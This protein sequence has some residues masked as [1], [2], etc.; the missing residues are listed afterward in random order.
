MKKVLSFMFAAAFAFAAC[1]PEEKVVPVVDVTMSSFGFYAVTNDALKSDFVVENPS[2]NIRIVLPY[3]TEDETLKSLVPTFVVTDGAVVTV[4]GEAVESGVTAF[5]FRHT[6][7]FL[8][9]VNEKSN[10]QYTV[11]VSVSG[12]AKWSK[13][14]VSEET[15]KA[16]IAL[17][18]GPVDESLYMFGYLKSTE[19]DS[20][21]LM[22]KYSDETI[23]AVSDVLDEVAAKYIA[24]NCSADG[25]P[26]S[27]FYDNTN[28]KM[29]VFC[30]SEGR[31]EEVGDASSLLANT[32]NSVGSNAIVPISRNDVWAFL[33]NNKADTNLGLIK[34]GLNVCHYDGNSWT[35]NISLPDWQ[36]SSA[37]Y[38]MQTKW[39]KG[40]PYIFIL[41][42]TLARLFVYK[43]EN[44][45][46]VTVCNG[47]QPL[48]NDGTTPISTAVY[49]YAAMNFD[50][51]SN[52]DIYLL[53]AADY[54]V[55]STDKVIGV[56]KYD[57][58]TKACTLV[59]GLYKNT[60]ISK[61]RY[62]SMA[63]DAN[64]VPY[65]V[66]GNTFLEGTPAYV[67]YV[68][69]KSKVWSDPV[70]LTSTK[71]EGIDIR[72]SDNGVGY[73]VYVDDTTRQAEVWTNQ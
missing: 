28:K 54:E 13:K 44:S 48:K 60:D 58:E 31:A 26:Y 3:G 22:M 70:A 2:E 64:D 39:V 63:L 9:T 29:R 34:R 5:D 17:A 19:K 43:Y 52:G 20:Y 72:F 55:E 40:V 53:A 62:M 4:D 30:V 67:T 35:Q 50:V 49:T 57:I 68:D 8:V 73:I 56:M 36:T 23:T 47:V 41:D 15:F 6:I 16:E 38:I 18:M 66:Y 69:S 7:E 14:A 37:T 27:V 21:P 24:A 11:T 59:G 25:T 10:A 42:F 71:T 1:T 45:Q 51:A 65:L 61:C 46:W 12:P 33:M 32:G